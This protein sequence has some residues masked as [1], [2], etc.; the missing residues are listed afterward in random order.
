MNYALALSLFVAGMV[1]GVGLLVLASEIGEHL[2]NRQRDY[3][4][5]DVD[6]S[7]VIKRWPPRDEL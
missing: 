5:I 4:P 7:N 6:A 1:V 3:P 2:R